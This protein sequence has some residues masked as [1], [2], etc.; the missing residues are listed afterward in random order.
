MRRDRGQRVLQSLMRLPRAAAPGVHLDVHATSTSTIATSVLHDKHPRV[1]RVGRLDDFLRAK[2]RLVADVAPGLLRGRVPLLGSSDPFRALRTPRPASCG[3]APRRAA[4]LFRLR[5]DWRILLPTAASTRPPTASTPIA[6]P[7]AGV[8]RVATPRLATRLATVGATRLAAS[9]V[10]PTALASALP[11]A[12][13]SALA[14]ALA[15]GGLPDVA[16]TRLASALAAR[17]ATALASA[18]SA[19]AATGGSPDVAAARASSALAA[20]LASAL[21]TASFLGH[22]Q[23]PLLGSV[24]ALVRPE[25]VAIGSYGQPHGK[26]NEKRA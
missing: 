3:A 16:A 19:V 25:Q 6:L 13:A 1:L 26:R 14:S 21:P 15:A 20:A 10:A 5:H 22:G 7:S 9:H 11:T 24:D 18:L 17:L 4:P 12:L 2:S 8:A 23:S